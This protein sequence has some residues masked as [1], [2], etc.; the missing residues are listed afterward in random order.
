MRYALAA[1]AAVAAL[2]AAA[3]GA[4]EPLAPGEAAIGA[5]PVVA[6]REL[7]AQRAKGADGSI[8]CSLCTADGTSTISGNAFQ[9]AVGVFTVVQNTGNQV[10]MNTVTVVN[11]TISK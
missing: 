5:A 7:A 10:F 1:S 11:V 4:A 6:D 9:N 8:L 2:W 3:A